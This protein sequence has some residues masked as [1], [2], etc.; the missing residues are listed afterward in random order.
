MLSTDRFASQGVQCE[1]GGHTLP[2]ADLSLGG[3]F[4]ACDP[5]LPRGQAVGFELAFPD[6]ARI[7]AVGRVAWVNGTDGAR[8][9]AR[10]TGCGI[11]ITRIAFPDKLALVGLLRRF[12]AAAAPPP[13]P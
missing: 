8:N 7:P 13:T 10:P 11:K 1:I 5:P 2:V 4:V 12:S 6:G 3:F 9:E